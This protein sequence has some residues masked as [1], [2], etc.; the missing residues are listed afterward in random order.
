MIFP[1]KLIS[2]V[3]GSMLLTSIMLSGCGAG[4]SSPSKYYVLSSPSDFLATNR[5]AGTRQGLRLGVGPISLPQHLD[6]SQIVTLASPHQLSLQELDQWAEPLKAGFSRIL[7]VN[8][9]SLL[10]TNDVFQYPW[11][12]PVTVQNQISVEVLRFDTNFKGESTLAA[13]WN[14]IRGDGQE[15]L[16]SQTSVYKTQVSGKSIEET[17]AAMSRNLAE[18]SREIATSIVELSK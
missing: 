10:Q 14:M 5:P 11:R 7:A 2:K 9:S 12:R 8:L 13:R 3:T 6:R 15:L 18:L 1:F 16:F 17:V 4:Q